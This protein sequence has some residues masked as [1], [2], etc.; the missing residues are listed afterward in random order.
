MEL[1]KCISEPS[2]YAQCQINEPHSADGDSN[3]NLVCGMQALSPGSFLTLS[4]RRSQ[5]HC[6]PPTASKKTA[7]RQVLKSLFAGFQKAAN[8]RVL[9]SR[10]WK[11]VAFPSK[12]A[13]GREAQSLFCRK[14]SHRPRK[15]LGR[16][17]RVCLRGSPRQGAARSS[18]FLSQ[19]STTHSTLSRR[20]QLGST[21]PSKGEAPPHH[22]LM[23]VRPGRRV[24]SHESAQT[25]RNLKQLR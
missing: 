8:G 19:R 7:Y 17:S 1:L 16:P 6:A 22:R 25:Q 3:L 12:I 24:A 18:R 15:H 2:N 13:N 21:S 10:Y 20:P 5:S 23:P 14:V 11:D 9:K 4:R